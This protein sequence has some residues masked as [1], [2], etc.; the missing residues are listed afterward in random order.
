MELFF[1]IFSLCQLSGENHQPL[2]GCQ[3][4]IINEVLGGK[5]WLNK[6]FVLLIENIFVFLN[7]GSH[8][9]AMNLDYRRAGNKTTRCAVIG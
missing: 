3:P 8:L 4:M 6:Y 7:N 9:N 1:A 5:T 2:R